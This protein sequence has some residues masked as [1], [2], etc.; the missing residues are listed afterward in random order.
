[1]SSEKFI[2][3]VATTVK[4]PMQPNANF[5][6]RVTL[7]MAYSITDL[8]HT[9]PWKSPG[10]TGQAVTAPKL[11]LLFLNTVVGGI[12]IYDHVCWVEFGRNLQMSWDQTK[13]I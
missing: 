9:L 11:A 2:D 1:M 5:I 7:S 4:G 3:P 6:Y 8:D 10:D 12:E 13:Y